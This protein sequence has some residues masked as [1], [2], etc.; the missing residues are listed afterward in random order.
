MVWLYLQPFRNYLALRLKILERYSKMQHVAL[1]GSYMGLPHKL[2][3]LRKLF[4]RTTLASEIVC[5]HLQ[6]LK[7]FKVDDAGKICKNATYFALWERAKG[8]PIRPRSS[9]IVCAVQGAMKCPPTRRCVCR[10][11]M[12]LVSST[13]TNWSHKTWNMNSASKFQCKQH[14]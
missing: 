11:K 8:M 3:I 2:Y 1:W 9:P 6:A 10:I 7:S 5:L 13:L 14:I 12:L 4:P